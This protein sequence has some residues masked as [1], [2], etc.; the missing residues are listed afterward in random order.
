MLVVDPNKRINWD[1]LIEIVLPENNKILNENLIY[2][3]NMKFKQN[4]IN[5]LDYEYS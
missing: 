1:E 5:N 2:K 3:Q 4:N